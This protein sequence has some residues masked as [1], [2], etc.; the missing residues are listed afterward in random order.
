MNTAQ[1]VV[2]AVQDARLAGRGVAYESVRNWMPTHLLVEMWR[3]PF[4][5]L[6][7]AREVE[8]ALSRASS[9]EDGFETSPVAEVRVHQFEPYGVSGAVRSVHANIV[10]HTWPEN[11]YAALDIYASSRDHA[12]RVLAGIERGLLP[13]SVQITE[14]NRGEYLYIEDT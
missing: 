12:Y 2:H 10:I 11:G 13:E 8:K 1:N 6:A 4:S 14:I 9:E 7:D 3:S 5:I